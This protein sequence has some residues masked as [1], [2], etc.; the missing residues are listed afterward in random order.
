MVDEQLLINK[1][2]AC[3]IDTL[4]IPQVDPRSN[5]VYYKKYWLPLLK[6]ER[7]C[8]DKQ[9]KKALKTAYKQ[10]WHREIDNG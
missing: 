4:M 10:N 2:I 1:V 7:V 5:I 9:I 3:G 6:P 8:Y